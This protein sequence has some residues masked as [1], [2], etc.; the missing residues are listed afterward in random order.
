MKSYMELYAEWLKANNLQD[1]EDQCK[2]VLQW[3]DDHGTITP[4]EAMVELG[5]M[6]LA[7]RVHEIRSMMGIPVDGKMVRDRN[8]YGTTVHYMKYKKAV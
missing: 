3:L 1:R 4:I 2:D 7:A 5:I 8:R 6:R